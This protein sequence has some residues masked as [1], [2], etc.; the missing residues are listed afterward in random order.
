M[1]ESRT[2][3]ER[4]KT[5][6]SDEP[7]RKCLFLFEGKETEPIY[8][9]KLKDLHDE[10]GISPLVDFIQIEKPR[11]EDWSNP[12][13][14]VDALCLDLS[15][16]PTYNTLINAMVDCLY[17]D[18]YLFRHRSKIK[19]FE[20]LLV[21]FMRDILQVK[22]SDLVDN[23]EETVKNTLE[24]FQKQWPNICDIILKHIEEMLQNYKITYEKDFD[25]LCIVV[26]R[27]PESFFE[28]QFDHVLKTCEK[29]GFK[30]LLSN[31]NFEFW[32]L[33]HFDDVLELDR[34]KIRLNEKINKNSA[35]SIRFVPDELRKRLGKYKKKCYDAESL[36][37]KIDTAICNEKQFTEALPELKNEIGSNIGTFIEE[38]RKII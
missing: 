33:L 28:W 34:D 15:E 19:E 13:K 5:K 16:T 26:D 3:G 30:F 2:F 25:I 9:S 38:L 36:I 31:P 7:K 23:V 4:C 35:S 24:Y 37:L 8:F 18:A 14:I 32:L 20:K 6:L 12:K 29:N 27:D 21:S 11:G 17:T 1:R 10:V 22:E